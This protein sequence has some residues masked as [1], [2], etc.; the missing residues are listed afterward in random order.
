MCHLNF[1]IIFVMIWIRVQVYIK[2]IGGLLE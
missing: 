2:N 1:N